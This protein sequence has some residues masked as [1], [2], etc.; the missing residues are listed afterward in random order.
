MGVAES[1]DDRGR[2]KTYGWVHAFLL[3]ALAREPWTV[4]D[5]ISCNCVRWA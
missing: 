5:Q 3:A 2:G 1:P 4:Y